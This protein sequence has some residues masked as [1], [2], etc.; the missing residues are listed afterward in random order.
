MARTNLTS[1][2]AR[3][4]VKEFINERLRRIA[5]S[6]NCGRL[7]MG[8]VSINTVADNNAITTTGLV[9]IKAVTIPLENA[10]LDERTVEQ[11]RTY[12]PDVSENGVPRFYAVRKINATTLELMLYPE[13]D[14]IYAVSIDGILTGTDL[15]A[16]GDVAGLPEDFHDVLIFGALADEYPHLSDTENS[17]I[18]E[19]KYE[20]RLKDL[21]YFLAKSAWLRRTEPGRDPWLYWWLPGIWA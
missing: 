1:T 16:D 6:T 20:A 10:I 19:G 11:L 21:R 9:H 12:D 17:L 18:F 2:T 5:T 8:T 13:P 4:R 7:R 15:S 14:A 3:T